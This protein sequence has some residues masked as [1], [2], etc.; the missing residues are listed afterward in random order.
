MPDI[1]DG[2]SYATG[3]WL[4]PNC[5]NS[6]AQFPDGIDFSW[7]ILG[8]EVR[9]LDSD[10]YVD[11]KIFDDE[12]TLKQTIRLDTNGKTKIDVSQYSNISS[13]QDIRIMIEITT[14]I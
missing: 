1:N 9:G 10:N 5:D 2:K 14:F 7:G 6:L 11:V 8:L 13:T 12:D 4:S 3:F